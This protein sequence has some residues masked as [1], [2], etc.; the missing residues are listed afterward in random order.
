MLV[1]T[2]VVIPTMRAEPPRPPPG[3]PDQ[4]PHRA[5]SRPRPRAAGGFMDR[6]EERFRKR[7]E[8]DGS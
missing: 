1:G 7:R 8:G 2:F 5:P 4:P 6:I 3:L